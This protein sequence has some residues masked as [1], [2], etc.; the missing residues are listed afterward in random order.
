MKLLRIRNSF[1]PSSC[2]K[3]KYPASKIFLKTGLTA[4]CCDEIQ[5]AADPKIASTT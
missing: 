3:I 1:N 4:A 2:M 5:Y